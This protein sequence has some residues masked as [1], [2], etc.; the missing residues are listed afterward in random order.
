MHEAEDGFD[1]Q[2]W[3]GRQPWSNGKIGTSGGS[4]LGLTQG[5]AA[6]L[7]S[8]FL[9]CMVPRVICADQYSGLFYPNEALLRWFDYWLKGVDNGGV[10]EPPIRLF[11]MGRTSGRTSRS[12]R[13]RGLTGNVGTSARADTRI[14]RSAMAHSRRHSR[15]TK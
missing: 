8:Q 3:I 14:R 4:D 6:P 2:D 1:T 10:D 13:W 15:A 5:A 9:T 12:G 7:A 11:I